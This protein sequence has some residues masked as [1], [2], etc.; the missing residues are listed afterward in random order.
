M[1]DE[2]KNMIRT[3]PDFPKP[4]IQFRDITS[5]IRQAD[6]LTSA[7]KKMSAPFAG[8]I[9][10]VAGIESRGFIFGTG[11]AMELVTGFVPLRKPGKLP[12]KTI[13][14]EYTLEYGT[15]ALEMHIDDMKAG[16]RVLL[17]DDLLATGGTAAAAVRLLRSSGAEVVAAVFLVELPD[18]GGRKKLE[19][20]DVI[21]LVEFKGD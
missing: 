8:K 19:N 21:S 3:I 4:G 9:D 6:G 16:Q 7:V 11:I 17:V 12:G 10:L 15:D 5:L 13:R 2:L 18:L 1:N 14:E 20:V